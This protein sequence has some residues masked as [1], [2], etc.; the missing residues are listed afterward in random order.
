MYSYLQWSPYNLELRTSKISQN[1]KAINVLKCPDNTIIADFF[2]CA[3]VCG[4]SGV[5]RDPYMVWCS[6]SQSGV[7]IL[8]AMHYE[9]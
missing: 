1:I 4:Q 3:Y 7:I 6:I 8:S 5:T 9:I 2:P